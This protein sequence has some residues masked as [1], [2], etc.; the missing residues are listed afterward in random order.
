MCVLEFRKYI[1]AWCGPGFC[2]F[3]IMSRKSC[4]NVEL[5]M[6]RVLYGVHII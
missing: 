1:G 3:V 4:E 6:N 2:C 5:E